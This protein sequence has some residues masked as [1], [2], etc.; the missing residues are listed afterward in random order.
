[1]I[2]RSLR[3]RLWT[4]FPTNPT[5]IPLSNHRK[6]L[7]L[8][9]HFFFFKQTADSSILS[10][11]EKRAIQYVYIFLLLWISDC[12]T[13]WSACE[14]LG[15]SFTFFF[16]TIHILWK[17]WNELW[18]EHGKMWFTH[19]LRKEYPHIDLR[20]RHLLEKPYFI[21]DC[22]CSY[23]YRHSRERE[24]CTIFLFFFFVQIEKTAAISKK[25]KKKY[26]IHTIVSYI[27]IQSFKSQPSAK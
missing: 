19:N 26:E 8:F 22:D 9:L 24:S 17:L 23:Q 20:R 5:T 4:N 18:N 7:L 10:S 6:R 16:F 14:S 25:K 11:L 27:Q 12:S 21:V 3:C 13:I 2:F 1:M 15:F